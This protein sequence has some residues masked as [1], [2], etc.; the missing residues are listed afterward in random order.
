[1][2]KK[3][4]IVD[5]SNILY[6]NFFAHKSS[7]LDIGIGMSIHSAIVS[8]N[9]FFRKYKP[10]DIVC[11][12]DSSNWRKIYT[13]SPECLTY[14]PY[15]GNRR[16]NLTPKLMEEFKILDAALLDFYEF[17]KNNTSLITLK[18]NLLEADDI[19]AGFVD[20][21]ISDRTIL[22]SSDRDYIQL[23]DNEFLTIVDPIKNEELT[24]SKW[25]NSIEYFLFEKMIRGDA[26]D[27]VMSSY[28][29]LSSKKIKE[30]MNDKILL[31]NIMNHEFVVEF[32]DE[33]GELIKKEY[34][35]KDVYEENEML[36]N[37]RKQPQYIR[38]KIYDTILNYKR[39]KFN[40]FSF[41]KMCGKYKLDKIL[42]SSNNYNECLSLNGG[43]LQIKNIQLF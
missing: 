41:I 18:A 36:M 8:L 39:S 21:V 9:Y 17:I 22:L 10:N 2:K 23:L 37:L 5:I 42:E 1:M 20:Y 40:Y 35:T 28:P 12:F 6:R 19:V 38:N 26:G 13:K 16:K 43:E 11:V 15:K 31:N 3:Y 7:G 25:D 34:L 27:N 4:L 14:K 29:K 24:L 32:I 30:A 33:A